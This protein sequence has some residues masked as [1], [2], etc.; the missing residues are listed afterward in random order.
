MIWTP[1]R[2]PSNTYRYCI[3]T[4]I[5]QGDLE[6]NSLTLTVPTPSVTTVDLSLP[7][8]QTVGVGVESNEI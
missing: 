4:L 2:K 6:T 5:I 3:D 8:T 7:S 1:T